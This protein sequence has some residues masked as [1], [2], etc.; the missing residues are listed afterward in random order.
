MQSPF[1][2]SLLAGPATA[3]AGSMKA[4]TGTPFSACGPTRRREPFQGRDN[5]CGAH[6]P[7]FDLRQL[8]MPRAANHLRLV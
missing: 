1:T 5:S 8:P 2:A 6:G 4:S 7:N 3:S